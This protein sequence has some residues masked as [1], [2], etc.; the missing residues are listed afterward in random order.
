MQA[1]I[2]RYP[3]K[4]DVYIQYGTA[5][6]R[7]KA[8]ELDHVVFRMGI[9]AALRSRAKGSAAIGLMIT[10]SHNPEPD[11]G[12]KLIDPHGEMLEMEWEE[13]ASRLANA[14]NPEFQGELAK[15]AM[16]NGI[17]A[18]KP[19]LVFIGRDS[20]SSSQRLAEAAIAGVKAYCGTAVD[21]GLVTTPMLHYYV[22]LR[23]T[24]DC[25]DADLEK[26][27]FSKLA[28][29]FNVLCEPYVQNQ[30]I[31]NKNYANALDFDGANGVGA[32]GI[33]KFLS[34]QK[35]QNFELGVH[36]HNKD[37]STPSKLN[38]ECGSDFVKLQM[39]PPNGF[40]PTSGRRIVSVDGDA[41]RVVYS[42][43][44]SENNFHLMDGDRIATLVASYLID[45][46][47]GSG[48]N[49]NLGLVQ[50]A[51]ANGNST[52]YITETLN[53]PVA[54]A[55]TG[56]KHLHHKALEFDIGVYFEAN[57]HGTVVFSNNAKNLVLQA[58]EDSTM[59]ESKLKWI[60]RLQQM[61]NLINS[62]VGDAISDMLL[63]EAI[64][65]A[66]GWSIQ[67]WE[68]A[69]HDLP[70]RLKKVYVKDRNVI[71]TVDADRRCSKPD[72]LQE[73]IDLLVAKYPNGRS[74]V[75]PSGTE[76]VVRVYAEAETEEDV[77]ALAEEVAKT[78]HNL[79]GGVG[80]PPS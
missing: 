63:V 33:D 6:F 75:R 19:A 15:V 10:A 8:T 18:A 50:T 4:N 37:L 68:T 16:S 49:L 79:A 39:K 67:D 77:V 54:C 57:G 24:T 1:E 5:G 3:R 46:V 59:D 21:H 65:L 2:D 11:N 44:D 66:R 74:F 56:V 22:F 12:V 27:Y 61:M 17:D 28:T 72:G 64:L 31:V 69:Y 73:Q 14:P 20:R 52:K 45:L 80:P 36:V 58:F 34:Y 35:G 70:S 13:I 48:L 62:T 30:T 47:K 26:S 53:I 78:V 41:D 23:N 76:D 60:R 7:T 38:H 40:K 32:V 51:Y 55:S 29:S 9:L 71:E 25:P 42:Y 43:V